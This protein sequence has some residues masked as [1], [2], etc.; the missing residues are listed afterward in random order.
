VVEVALGEAEEAHLMV[1]EEEGELAVVEVSISHY[2]KSV[3]NCSGR[4]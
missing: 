4:S 2:G 1:E 3:Q